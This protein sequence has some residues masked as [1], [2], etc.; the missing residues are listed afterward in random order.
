M[1]LHLGRGCGHRGDVASEHVKL[2]NVEEGEVPLLPPPA[3]HKSISASDYCV[4]IGYGVTKLISHL[5]YMK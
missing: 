1:T 3:V 5:Y 2:G 4:V